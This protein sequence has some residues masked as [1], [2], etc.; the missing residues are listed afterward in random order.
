MS[1]RSAATIK[2]L[3]SIMEHCLVGYVASAMPK[4]LSVP[5]ISFF[6]VFLMN[7]AQVFQQV[8]QGVH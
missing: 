7:G 2:L 1:L 8:R 6:L 5:R 3:G 4:S